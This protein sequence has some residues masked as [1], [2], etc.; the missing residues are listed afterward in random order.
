MIFAK[1]PIPG[2]A[3]TR[4][5]PALGEPGSACLAKR[6]L[7]HATAEAVNADL[8]PVV[9]YASPFPMSQWPSICLP[10]SLEFNPQGTGDLG[11]RLTAAC[12]QVF[13]T[14]WDGLPVIITGT[15]CPGL[16]SEILG[17]IS[18]ELADND[19]VLVP[20]SDGGYVA[21]GISRFSASI[22]SDID[23]S[24]EHVSRQTIERFE[25]LGW[26][27]AILPQMHDIDEQQ[28]LQWLPQSWS[29]KDFEQFN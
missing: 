12:E 2:Y 8:G 15:D 6:L 22:F 5:I 20:A 18:S 19:A 1:A 28:D 16:T 10:Q 4:L 25:T 21:M 9:L 3:K 29:L 7:E 13:G 27:Y 26:R 24:T 23:W 17:Q 11:A 14:D